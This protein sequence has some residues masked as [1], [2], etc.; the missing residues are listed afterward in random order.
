MTLHRQFRYFCIVHFYI[1]HFRSVHFCIVALLFCAAVL[2]FPKQLAAQ[3]PRSSEAE[4]IAVL[5]RI[6]LTKAGNEEIHDAMLACYCLQH[7]GSDKSIPALEKC[8]TDI[9]LTT[10]AR[11]A[12]QNIG[13]GKSSA[14]ADVLR[15]YPPRKHNASPIDK[16]RS[17]LTKKIL[18]DSNDI[19]VFTAALNSDKT[20]FNAALAA[21]RR[22]SERSI[23]EVLAKE[24]KTLNPERRVAALYSFLDRKDI[25]PLPQEIIEAAADTNPEVRAAAMRVLGAFPNKERIEIL[26]RECGGTSP[27]ICEAAMDIL[28]ATK[29]PELNAIVLEKLSDKDSS[30]RSAAVRLSGERSIKKVESVLWNI[31]NEQPFDELQKQTAAALGRIA[32]KNTFE[33][34]CGGYRTAGTDNIRS[35]YL[36]G[37][38]TACPLSPDREFYVRQITEKIKEPLLQLELFALTGGMPSLQAVAK[39]ASSAEQDEV[40]DKA[41][42]ILGEW[43]GA[44]VAPVLLD[45]ASAM[46]NE[47]YKIRCIRGMLRAVRQFDMPKEQKRAL[48]EKALEIITGENEKK[49]L[50]QQLEQLK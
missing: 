46:K 25:E 13:N 38:K 50:E 19:S 34:L 6:D 42:Q 48:C 26:F 18:L 36:E 27:E 11:A 24:Q 35:A 39:I 20:S 17:E 41:T 1:V 5:D 15:K 33:K 9:R 32:N 12:L 47:K 14:A 2:F 23:V 30:I 8:L 40:L 29:Y 49:L 21:F 3:L 16:K 7:N 31:V 37:I 43:T 28:A 45:L 22:S 10:Y 44:E 4:S